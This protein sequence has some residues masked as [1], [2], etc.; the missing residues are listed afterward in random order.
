MSA[1]TRIILG[2]GGA[3]GHDANAALIV[4]GR[5]IAAS[6]EE[7]FS[8]TK[9]DSNLPQAAIRDCLAMAGLGLGDVAHC[10]FADKPLQFL[11]SNRLGKPSNWLTWQLGKAVREKRFGH[12]SRARDLLPRAKFHYA[13]HHLAHAAVAFA[14]SP[15]ERAAFLCVDGK[16]DDV[17]ATIGAADSRSTE[18]SHELAYDDGIGSLYSLL[19]HLLGFTNFGAEYKV[20]GLAPF[21]EPAYLERLRSFAWSDPDGALRLKV[22]PS[23]P[24]HEVLA[25]LS[26]HLGVRARLNGEAIGEEHVN[27]A[28]SVQALFE[29][30]IFRMADFARRVTGER[31]LLFCG[32]CAQN[33]VAAGKLRSS[34]MFDGVFASPAA[35]DMGTGLG[36]ALLYRQKAGLQGDGKIDASGFH[37]GSAPG[38]PP[39]EA[40]EFRVSHDGDIFEAAA[41][42]LAQGKVLGWVRGRMELGPRALGARSILADPRVANM[43]SLLNLKIKFRESFRPFAPAILAED[44]GE[45]FN[46][47]EPS[48]YM[49]YVAYLKPEHRRLPGREPGGWRERLA[50]LRCEFPSVVH[51]DYSARLQ[52][53]RRDLHPDFHRLLTECKKLTGFPM[54]I[55]TSF[56]V[57]GEPIVRT[58]NDAWQ[59]FR[60]TEMDYL[61]IDDVLLRNPNDKTIGE[62][63]EW[64]RQFE[65]YS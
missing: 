26:G 25:L 51:V 18:I 10:V 3:S 30:Q 6:Q 20:M 13:W 23:M 43:Q 34:G 58:A 41:R 37:L 22:N 29:E 15:Y 47:T 46:S 24:L 64:L 11:L 33:C 45:W 42:L 31:F 44:C 27:L 63:F 50:F 62:K 32:G 28:A 56:N 4:D 2:V 61:V 54:I 21:G 5:L 65:K 40:L 60:H 35:G 36:A 12:L 8:R 16:G 48:D 19:T 17:S 39:D 9:H 49:Q 57:S 53:V 14:T 1:D 7:R 38:D 55:N 59:C 52:T